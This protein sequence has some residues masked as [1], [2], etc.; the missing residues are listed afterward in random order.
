MH[1]E[2]AILA[3]FYSTNYVIYFAVLLY[4]FFPL[5]KQWNSL[6]GN[7]CELIIILL[8]FFLGFLDLS[9]KGIKIKTSLWELAFFLFLLIYLIVDY[10]NLYDSL[11][12]LRIFFFYI[13]LFKVLNKRLNNKSLEVKYILKMCMLVTFVMSFGA[14]TQFVFPEL[15]TRFHPLDSL[16]ELRSKS[17]YI[18]FSFYNRAFS[19]MTDP[20]VLSV[21]L[22]F[23][24]MLLKSFVKENFNNKYVIFFQMIVLTAIILTQSRTGYIIFLCYILLDFMRERKEKKKLKR[25]N[26][27]Y[28]LIFL[29]VIFW[30]SIEFR[31]RI[32]RFIRIDTLFNGNGRIIKTQN[33]L[34]DLFMQEPFNL[35]FGNGLTAG[36]EIIFENSY[37]LCIYMFGIAGA[38]IFLFLLIGNFNTAFKEKNFIATICFLL[39]NVVGDY[40]LIPQVTMVVIII[41]MYNNRKKWSN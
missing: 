29:G 14:I 31:D 4:P 11:S 40:L 32:L 30:G 8:L 5:I 35:F 33:F 24:Y 17:N 28:L 2:E 21:Y 39:A 37:L 27:I 41:W 1:F 25:N 19:F 15:I 7:I 3:T 16:R 18:S 26:I 22:V 20:N 36:R 23:N 13:C 9:G 6:I 38:I 12:G 10:D 34:D